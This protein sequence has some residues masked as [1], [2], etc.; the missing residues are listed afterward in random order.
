MNRRGV[1][2]VHEIDAMVLEIETGVA[3]GDETFEL[4]ELPSDLRVRQRHDVLRF[5]ERPG[6]GERNQAAE[7]LKKVALGGGAEQRRGN[8]FAHH[9]PDD[10]VE[11]IVPVLE[12]IVEV[13]VDSLRRNRERGHAYARHVSGRLVEQE[14]LLNLEADLDFLLARPSQLFLR[15]LALGDVFGD[16]DQI[17]R[18]SVGAEDRDLEGVQEAQASMG[19]LNGFLGN[20]HHLTAIQHGPVFRDEEAGLLLGEEIVVASPD[21]GAAVDAERL[22]L[23]LVPADEF[24]VL[25]IF[26]KSMTGRFSSTE[27]RKFLASSSSAVR[28]A[29]TSS[30]RRWSVSSC[31]NWALTAA[32]AVAG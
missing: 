1:A 26:T 30:V 8:P 22:F 25:G 14:R 4:D 23:R 24:Q 12:E 18:L 20:L 29:S 32:S 17:L 13:A 2:A 11:A 21:G 10:D 31:S 3:D 16:A 19:C 27:S 6:S 7:R 28:F 5:R 9:V 15:P